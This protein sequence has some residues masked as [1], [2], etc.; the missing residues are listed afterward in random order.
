MPPREEKEIEE[1][2]GFKPLC[3]SGVR[4]KPQFVG[5]TT[6]IKWASLL[7]DKIIVL[8]HK[9]NAY[10][11]YPS[12]AFE[13]I[14]KRYFTFDNVCYSKVSRKIGHYVQLLFQC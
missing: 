5:K 1:T 9:F 13:H 8:K 3:A 11:F 14:V 12:N 4:C 6:S 10:L 7:N 2:N